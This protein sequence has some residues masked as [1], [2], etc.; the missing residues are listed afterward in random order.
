MDTAPAPVA[1]APTLTNPGVRA[2]TPRKLFVNLP[3]AD[4]QRT[5]TFFEGLGFTFNAQ[6]TGPDTAAMHIGEDAYAM[7]MTHARFV[8]FSNRPIPDLHTH[9]GAIFALGVES[10][11]AVDAM[12]G[13]AVATGGTPAQDGAQDH[14]FMYGNSFHD[15]DGHPWEVFW[16]DPAHVRG[17]E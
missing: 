5:V 3:V 10:R 16:M 14:G 15:P 1:A 9:T 17:G 2:A 12:L 11:A 6:F 13:R 7:F 8:G 4:V